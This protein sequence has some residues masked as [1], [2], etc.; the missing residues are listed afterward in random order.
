[1]TTVKVVCP[2]CDGVGQVDMVDRLDSTFMSYAYGVRSAYVTDV[3]E[4]IRI[5]N[6]ILSSPVAESTVCS[7]GFFDLSKDTSGRV[8][9]L[10]LWTSMMSYEGICGVSGYTPP[11][12]KHRRVN[13]YVA[14][15][16][17]DDI[18]L[19]NKRLRRPL[20]EITETLIHEF[21]HVTDF[22]DKLSS[23]GHGG[24]SPKGKNSTAPRLVAKVLV[25]LYK[26]GA[27]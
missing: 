1:M 13:A 27:I 2:T 24:N 21:I 25:D 15:K 19:N 20:L 8:S 14:R 10:E 7:M 4:A 16:F 12:W 11:W 17:P 5:A 18:K 3:K 9:G 22:N 23:Y 26:Q 6:R